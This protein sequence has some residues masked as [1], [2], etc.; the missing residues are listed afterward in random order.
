MAAD[1]D[2][3]PQWLQE[4]ERE[5]SCAVCF[6]SF[7]D[8]RILPCLHYY[9]RGC[10]QLIAS[11]G[12]PCPECRKDVTLPGGDSSGLPKPF[13]VNRLLDLYDKLVKANAEGRVEAAC[14]VCSRSGKAANGFCRQCTQFICSECARSHAASEET[15]GH[16]IVTL[17]RLGPTQRR[18]ASPSHDGGAT[19][20]KTCAE[21]NEELKFFCFTCG[22]LVCR[23]CLLSG[24]SSH[25]HESTKAAAS[26]CREKLQED[27]TAVETVRNSIAQTLSRVATEKERV[28]EQH[29]SASLS[30]N[31]AIDRLVLVLLQRKQELLME[32][33]ELAK[34][35]TTALSAQEKGLKITLSE[36]EDALQCLRQALATEEEESLTGDFHR[37]H[38]KS[39]AAR[40]K[41]EG[42]EVELSVSAD[43]SMDL[44]FDERV[45]RQIGSLAFMMPDASVCSADGPCIQ[46]GG[47]VNKE[48]TVSVHVL[49]SDQKPFTGNA[50][51]DVE[52]LCLA[53]GSAH[54]AQATAHEANRYT[55]AYTPTCRGKYYLT[56]KVNHE[57][58]AGSPFSI[59]VKMPPALMKKPAREI[60]AVSYPHGLAVCPSGE[61]LVA[62]L[63]D[64]SI[65]IIDTADLSLK[66]EIKNSQLRH[67]VGVTA[68]EHGDIYVSDK[69]SSSI[70]K[71]S[72]DGEV[73][74]Q[75]RVA[76]KEVG[77]LTA[78]GSRLFVCQRGSHEVHVLDCAELHPLRVIGQ[79]G[80]GS[81]DFNRPVAVA[82]WQR[83]IFITDGGNRR[84]QVFGLA[85][86]FVRTFEIHSPGRR[87]CT[88]RGVGVGPSGLLYVACGGAPACLLIFTPEGNLVDSLETAENPTGVAVDEHGFVYV[89]SHEFDGKIHVY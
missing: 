75:G 53:N 83:E 35:K 50:I 54:K 20:G 44:S 2:V 11:K 18:L 67:P 77:M 85:G 45:L 21:H 9:C 60:P 68:D 51:V 39:S 8:P 15:S 69:C 48:T 65:A 86:K 3:Q 71:F 16:R 58:V 42:E 84:V 37:V 33:S 4:L 79:Q 61:L 19:N 82:S 64:A 7:S 49:D 24:H 57:E 46:D 74:R 70:L 29:G 6:E 12:Q 52:F 22:R 87:Q 25:E 31:A 56:I 63:W 1:S 55:A 66:D 72:R 28:T 14:E 47:E 34:E 81:G 43:L 76:G 27:L 78:V 30:V 62:Q 41:C 88:P 5:I 13:F 10:I 26:Y 36:A 38:H 80:T 32:L 59:F 89:S 17:D 23:D 40:A 73:L